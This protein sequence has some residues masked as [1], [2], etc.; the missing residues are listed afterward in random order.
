MLSDKQ[1][2]HTVR[3]L[4]CSLLRV[5]ER[6]KTEVLEPH[7]HLRQELQHTKTCKTKP[8][9]VQSVSTYYV[10]C[11]IICSGNAAVKVFCVI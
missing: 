9:T 6:I 1:Y 2:F 7:L 8:K 5:L 10:Y 11:L 3:L 4:K